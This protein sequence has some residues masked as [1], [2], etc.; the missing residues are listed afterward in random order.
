VGKLE[1]KSVV[2]VG[3]NVGKTDGIALGDDEGILVGLLVGLLVC[4]TYSS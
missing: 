1:G 2:R 4:F 3:S